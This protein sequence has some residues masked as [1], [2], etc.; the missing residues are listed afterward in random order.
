MKTKVFWYTAFTAFSLLML[1]PIM[2]AVSNSFKTLSDAFSTILSLI[3]HSPTV[4]NYVFLFERLDILRITGN[5]LFIAASVT[6]F[7]LAT[8][9]FAA[10]ALVFFDFKYKNLLYFVL[11]ATIFIPFTVTMIP[12]FLTISRLSLVDNPIGVI[13]PQLADALGI[14]LMRQ[15]MKM[16]PK[17]LIEYA[18]L[19]N[20]GHLRVMK[21]I[22]IPLIKPA[23]IS[24]GIIFFIN[25]WNEFVWPMLILRSNENFTLPL[26]LQMF[27]SAEG[28]SNFTYAM[29]LSVVSMVVPLIL[30][31]IFQRHIISTFISSGVK[32]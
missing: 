29:A 8:G 6:A 11:I 26:A 18:R 22:V 31:L 25:S 14:F 24:T 7:K 10:Y 16:I 28:G 3:P 13:L 19:E 2:F 23:I 15:S 21:D 5:T 12:N 32:G 9:I 27:I 17:P 20:L 4:E 1:Y 30:F